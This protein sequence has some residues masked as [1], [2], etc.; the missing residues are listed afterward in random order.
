ML[1]VKKVGLSR[2]KGIEN[3]EK[4]SGLGSKAEDLLVKFLLLLHCWGWKPGPR[5]W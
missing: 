4:F 2:K 3:Q 5:A 1:E